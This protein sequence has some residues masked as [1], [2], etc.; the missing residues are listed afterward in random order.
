MYGFY[1]RPV[2]SLVPLPCASLME[3]C[4]VFKDRILN[5]YTGLGFL[6]AIN[7]LGSEQVIVFG[8][9]PRSPQKVRSPEP[10]G[11]CNRL[12]LASPLVGRDIQTPVSFKAIPVGLGIRFR[13]PQVVARGLKFL[14]WEEFC[15]IIARLMEA[16]AESA[17]K[18][19]Q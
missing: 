18:S 11:T 1:I 5:L 15:A 8:Q 17:H 2:R 10:T 9:T 13:W 19:A 4:V 16:S 7:P 12:L 6:L 3:G 14:L